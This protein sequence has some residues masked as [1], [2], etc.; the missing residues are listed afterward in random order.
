MGYK[1]FQ[2]PVMNR[3]PER[4]TFGWL[5]KHLPVA[6]WLAL[7]G[8]IVVAF[9]LGVTFGRTT[10]VAEMLGKPTS[11]EKPPVPQISPDNLNR[12]IEQLIQGHNENLKNLYEGIANE[13]R[14][15]A[16]YTINGQD[17]INSAKRLKD[18]LKEENQTFEQ[19]V[20]L[21]R[22]LQK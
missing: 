17:H 11:P 6:V 1:G 9:G 10:F 21:L 15:A 20:K 18:T 19:Q 22:D 8:S 14:S 12:R 5:F 13:E 16:V 4:V 7:A 2:Y 3:V